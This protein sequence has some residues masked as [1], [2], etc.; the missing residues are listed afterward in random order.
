MGVRR[1]TTRHRVRLGHFTVPKLRNYVVFM[2]LLRGGHYL[3]HQGTPQGIPG[4]RSLHHENPRNHNLTSIG[5]VSTEQAGLLIIQGTHGLF[6][7]GIRLI[8]TETRRR[9]FDCNTVG[10]SGRA[11]Q[12]WLTYGISPLKYRAISLQ[13]QQ[14]SSDSFQAEGWQGRRTEQ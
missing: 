11:I 7:T 1:A 13:A 10:Q 8:T 5:G 2:V 9:Q 14:V 6:K 4:I 3:A 12:G